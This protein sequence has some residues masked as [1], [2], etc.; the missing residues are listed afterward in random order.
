MHKLLNKSK[1]RS[2]YYWYFII[3]IPITI[4]IDSSVVLG[5]RPPVWSSLVKWHCQSNNDFLLMEKP[6]WL[7]WFVLVELI[8]QLPLFFYLVINWSYLRSPPMG[9]KTY[10]L[11]TYLRLYGLEAALTTAVCIWA[12]WNRDNISLE[13]QLQLTF[14]YLPTVIIPGRLCSL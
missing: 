3:H 13:N 9:K 10:R 1:E 6:T 11:I 2:F 5:D 7:W 14:V 4:F 12:I 8:F